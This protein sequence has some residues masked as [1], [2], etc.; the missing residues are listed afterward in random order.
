MNLRGIVLGIGLAASA[1]YS[2][3]AQDVVRYPLT[4]TP[5]FGVPLDEEL[6]TKA[7][8]VAEY[9]I[10]TNHQTVPQRIPG[11]QSARAVMEIGDWTYTVWVVNSNEGK[12]RVHGPDSLTIWLLPRGAVEPNQH[13]TLSDTGLDGKCDFGIIGKGI[14][15]GGRLTFYRARE[16]S[17][18][19]ENSSYKEDLQGLYVAT[20]NTFLDF[21]GG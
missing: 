20:L 16:G 2:A 6:A 8:K 5:D 10:I 15:K 18:P 11:Y 19:E 7:R 12:R 14:S 9:V 4:S 21:Y 1:V 17:T 13:I 3:H